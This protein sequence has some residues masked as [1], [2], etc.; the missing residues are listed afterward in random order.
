MLGVVPSPDKMPMLRRPL[1]P[2]LALGLIA[3][4]ATAGALVA[5]GRSRAAAVDVPA[6]AGPASGAR[7]IDP[8][9]FSP[10]ACVALPPTGGNRHM[11]VFLDAGHGGIDPGAVGVTQS[12][13]SVHEALLTLPVELDTAR[14]L[15]ARGFRVVVSRTRNSSVV[16]LTRADVSAGALTLQGAHD[17]VAARDLCAD[18]AHADLLV[19]IY[20]DAGAPGDAGSVTGYDAVRSFAAANLRFA[21]LL[22]SDVLEAMNAH[23]WGIPDEGVIPDSQLGSALSQQA[24]AY[25]HLLLLGPAKRGWLAEPSR[26]PGALIEP[27]FITDPFEASIAASAQGQQVIAGGIARAVEQYFAPAPRRARNQDRGRRR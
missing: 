16:R 15:R 22:Q 3:T 5:G 7:Q 21:E 10:G 9:A 24:I 19:G 2:L 18:R 27:L 1:M 12:G 20:F 23:G 14:L 11:T 8:A 6:A 13:R 26:M 17:D 4:A 25:G